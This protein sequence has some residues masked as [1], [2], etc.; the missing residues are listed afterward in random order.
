MSVLNNFMLV[1]ET[2]GD[3]QARTNIE[4]LDSSAKKLAKT[5]TTTGKST[6]DMGRKAKSAS[7]QFKQLTRALA[8]AV[9]PAMALSAVL[10]RT[11]NFSAQGEQLLFMARSANM[12]ADEFQ[13]LA[14]ASQRFGGSR[15]GAAGMMAGLA[16]QIQALRLGQSA[17]LQDAAIYYGLNLQGKDGGLA[18]G[19]ELLRNIAA[20]M[21]RLDSA[22]QLDLGHRIGLDEATIRILQQGVSAFDEELARAEKRSV[23]KPEDLKRAQELQMA[24]R[25]LQLSMQGLWAEITR[26]LLPAVQN[27]TETATQAFDYMTEHADA[28]KAV[29]VGISV[30]M[31]AIAVSSLA[32][33]APWLGMAAIVAAV[34]AAIALVYEDFMVFAKGGESALAPFWEKLVEFGKWWQDF[35]GWIKDA[36]SVLLDLL[37]PFKIITAALEKL[38]QLKEFLAKNQGQDVDTAQL[39]LNYADTNPLAAVPAGSVS[40]AYNTANSSNTNNSYVLTVNGV[41]NPVQGGKELLN[42]ARNEDYANLTSGQRA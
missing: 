31:G 36:L 1:F 20:T 22:A 18:T 39:Q 12:A 9:A 19:N 21:E 28:V 25:D 41:A 37:N 26:W 23:F 34:G 24:T 8:G 38:K 10:T 17:P 32:A 5:N 30:I 33:F 13:K 16:S 35:P 29:L 27:L 14:I 15:E 6:E 40:T 3:A 2:D 11:L 7:L 4:K 42:T